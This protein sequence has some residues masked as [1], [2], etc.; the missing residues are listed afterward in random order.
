MASIQCVG[1]GAE[2][3]RK[4]L[5]PEINCCKIFLQYFEEENAMWNAVSLF[6]ACQIDGTNELSPGSSVSEGCQSVMLEF[7]IFIRVL[8]KMAKRKFGMQLRF[9]Y[10][11][12]KFCMLDNVNSYVGF[13]LIGAKSSRLI[14]FNEAAYFVIRSYLKQGNER[15]K[16]KPS[17]TIRSSLEFLPFIVRHLPDVLRS[18]NESIDLTVL[19]EMISFTVERFT[20]LG[21]L[22]HKG[23]KN[24]LTICK[25]VRLDCLAPAM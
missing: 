24:P 25:A 13:A 4:L 6:R 8:K 15:L 21:R 11:W 7:Q 10:F 19:T 3:S 14:L 20:W 22:S 9:S 2:H 17:Q 16:S 12:R 18:K 5:E 1:V 23:S